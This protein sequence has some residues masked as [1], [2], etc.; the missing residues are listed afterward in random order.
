M[1]W[2]PFYKIDGERKHLEVDFRVTGSASFLAPPVAPSPA[3]NAMSEQNPDRRRPWGTRSIL[4][5]LFILHPHCVSLRVGSVR[6]VLFA[7]T[8]PAGGYN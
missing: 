7:T 4:A 2:L 8:F 1:V 5:F 6:G 3:H